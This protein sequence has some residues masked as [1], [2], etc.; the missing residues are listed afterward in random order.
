M[1]IPDDNTY[2][3]GKKCIS[4]YFQYDVIFKK[5]ILALKTDVLKLRPIENI[6]FT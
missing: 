2:I 1:L 6:I 5:L 3:S 4:S